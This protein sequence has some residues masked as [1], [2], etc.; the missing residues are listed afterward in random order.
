MAKKELPWFGDKDGDGIPNLVDCDPL[1]SSKHGFFKRALHV[2][3]RG[4]YGQSSED[5]EEEKET[6]RQKKLDKLSKKTEYLTT[7]LAKKTEMTEAKAKLKEAKLRLKGKPRESGT[8]EGQPSRLGLAKQRFEK[9]AEQARAYQAKS[10]SA[11]PT[12][13]RAP[14]QDMFG[15]TS[16]PSPKSKK[17]I[18][19]SGGPS[20]D[21]LIGGS[22]GPGP[23]SKKRKGSKK[24]KRKRSNAEFNKLIG[25]W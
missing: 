12:S 13:T 25:G 5:Y 16:T 6:K 11:K 23:S 3:S 7:K 24:K 15:F 17:S 19:P 2:A 14:S 9:M 18:S 21:D 10:K 8:G 22:F 4:K 1:D 20:F